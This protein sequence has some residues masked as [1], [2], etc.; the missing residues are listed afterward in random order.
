[1]KGYVSISTLNEEDKE[2][3]DKLNQSTKDM[4]RDQTVKM[5]E[6]KVGASPS[7]KETKGGVEFFRGMCKT[8]NFFSIFDP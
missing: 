1:M 4:F 8:K 7:K 2:G 3:I 6:E 5:E